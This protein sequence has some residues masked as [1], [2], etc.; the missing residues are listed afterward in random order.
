MSHLIY[1]HYLFYSS[2][3]VGSA[4][5]ILFSTEVYFF[6]EYGLELARYQYEWLEKDLKVAMRVYCMYVFMCVEF[7]GIRYLIML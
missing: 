6:V 5:F 2:W 3:D 7:E 4:H 1:P